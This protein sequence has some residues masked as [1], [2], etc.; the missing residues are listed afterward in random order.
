MA[1]TQ[2]SQ[3]CIPIASLI[4]GRLNVLIRV[5]KSTLRT[6]WASNLIPFTTT[7]RTAPF[8]A[9]DRVGEFG[10]M[11]FVTDDDGTDGYHHYYFVEARTAAQ[12]IVKIDALSRVDVIPK[13]WDTCL[14][15]LGA[16][17]DSTE[18]LNVSL[19][20]V[21]Q[22]LPRLFGRHAILPGGMYATEI[23]IEVYVSHEPFTRDFFDLVSPVPTTV[24]WDDRNLRGSLT[25]LHDL[26]EFPETQTG[27]TVLDSWGTVKKRLV[28]GEKRVFPAT[29]PPR[30]TS[31][32][33]DIQH[34]PKANMFQLTK[35]RCHPPRGARKI[36]Q[37]TL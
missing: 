18:P 29:N 35:Y 6:T 5:P 21:T 32:V 30:W 27:A 3:Q 17:T 14:L 11:I 22:D 31:H 13:S 26:V 37:A 24:S 16:L 19:G 2:E 34:T 1:D 9:R 12:K 15:S 8:A 36:L 10:D 25:C 28:L 33:Y 7:Y 4:P 23:D 20:G